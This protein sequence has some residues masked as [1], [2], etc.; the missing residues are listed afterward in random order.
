MNVITE[1][2]LLIFLLQFALLLGACKAVGF[3]LEKIHQP[4]ITGD[5]LV[6]LILGPA[7]FGRYAPDLQLN[8][9]PNEPVQWAMLG[10]VAWFGN[11][12]L[13]METGLEINFSKVWKQ[14]GDAI[15]LS[16]IDLIVPLALCF[17]PFYFLPSSYLVDPSQRTIFALF[18]ASV[19]TISALPVAIRGLKE[20]GVLKTDMGFLIV[21]AL[22]INDIV[23]WVIF[24]IILG[25]FAH[26]VVEFAFVI[27][28]IVLTLAFTL[29]S[30][31][32][33]KRIVDKAITL[34]HTKIGHETGYKTTFI[35]IIGML[36]GAITL[37]IGIHSLFGFFIA[38]IVVGE[39]KHINEQ[40]RHTIHR[41]V[42]S[43]FVPI[44][45]AKIGLQINILANLDIPL[46][47]LI[48]ILG[49]ASR[50]IGAYL[51][52]IWAK[53]DKVNLSSIAIS[54]TAGGEMHIVVAMLAYSAKLINERVFVSVVAASIFSTIIFG[55]WLSLNLRK[56]RNK[57]VNFIFSKG[58][59]F[60][61]NSSSTKDELLKTLIAKA[62]NRIGVPESYLK[63]EVLTREDQMSTAVG[64][65][66]AF[67][68]ARLKG[69]NSSK[70]FVVKTDYGIDWDSPDGI[71]VK[72]VF[73]TISPL[74]KPEAQLK[75]IQSL[76]MLVRNPKNLAKLMQ[77]RDTGKLHN[78][79]KSHLAECD[80][81]LI[82][83]AT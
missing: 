17:L 83:T 4:T 71:G 74:E 50:Y 25:I 35:V 59:V 73:F 16:F 63:N 55:P 68:H 70:L 12:F 60:L 82:A 33:L 3:L 51:G 11:L 66:V 32:L 9:F 54:H 2:H 64:R 29:V 79:L 67:P 81:C 10:T 13:L 72:L 56:V 1:H 31:T 21:S 57:L 34:I 44:F 53:Q 42:Y 5:V 8:I 26:G 7:I 62:A 69:L 28:L 40:D 58:D 78:L 80:D 22:T 6:G 47:A 49:V 37:K 38:G 39:A 46:V 52:A 65:A 43:I 45:F 61:D 18:I 19:M 75:L 23:G 76:S 24:T 27:R 41:M 77:T 14:R 20:L 48:T 15:K 36:M 30:L